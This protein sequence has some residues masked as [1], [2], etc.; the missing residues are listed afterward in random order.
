M[1]FL[2]TK[3]FLCLL[4]ALAI[5]LIV[6]WLLRRFSALAREAELNQQIGL[7]D[8]QVSSLE[9]QV[10]D[11]DSK[12]MALGSDLDL[13]QSKVPKLESTLSERDD[14]VMSLT[15]DLD[16]WKQKVP[17]LEN[18][19]RDLTAQRTRLSADLNSRGTALEASEADVARLTSELDTTKEQLA[20]RSRRL[21]DETARLTSELAEQ[22]QS[23]DA[24][25]A[26]LAAASNRAEEAVSRGKLLDADLISLRNQNETL[27]AQATENEKSLQAS[28][29]QAKAHDAERSSLA[30]QL[31]AMAPVAARVD[32]QDQTIASL[33]LDLRARDTTIKGLRDELAGTAAQAEELH[34]SQRSLTLL[35]SELDGMRGELDT[36]K[37]RLAALPEL[38]SG[39][40]TLRQELAAAQQVI[41]AASASTDDAAKEKSRAADKD[42]EWQQRLRIAESGRQ[43]VQTELYRQQERVQRLEQ[44][45]AEGQ[46]ATGQSAASRTQSASAAVA[47]AAAGALAGRA[48]A[49]SN[50]AGD[51][52]LEQR[53]RIAE[54]G[55]QQVQ[56]ELYRQQDQVKKLEQQLA[57]AQV[58][59]PAASRRPAVSPSPSVPSTPPAQATGGASSGSRFMTAPPSASDD[60]RKIKGVGKVL[61]KTLNDLGIY[62][63][64]QVALFTEDDIAWVDD[65]LKFKGRITRDNWIGQARDLH[66][67]KHGSDPDAK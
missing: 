47:G 15:M 59:R 19:L 56:A 65:R 9:G 51:S 55:R 4:L 31:T 62:Q 57:Q 48:S 46:K 33:N 29:D 24:T 37:T 43:Q 5:G 35:R 54:S 22:K 2:L 32:S 58:S 40:A 1:S 41:S 52:G 44:Q 14:Q 53:L 28:R 34:S 16:G 50:T 38:E 17:P 3:I 25:N 63:Y 21:A 26:Q 42:R 60:L 6:G 20:D 67:E 7:R 64:A 18:Q 61:Q 10:G 13:W 11:R 23:L 39:N 8:E 49:G 36:Q 12:I 30:Q 27:G 66:K 45:L